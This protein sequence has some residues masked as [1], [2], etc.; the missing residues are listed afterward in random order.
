M[1]SWTTAQ[2][3]LGLWVDTE[4]MTVGLPQRTPEDLQ[5]RL[6]SWPSR[7]RDVLLREV[8]S[9]SRKLHPAACFV[10]P[11]LY[12]VHRLLRL[13]SLYLTVEGAWSRVRKSGGEEETRTDYCRVGCWKW[14]VN[15]DR[16]KTMVRLAIPFFRLVKQEPSRRWYPDVSY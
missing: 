11:R 1:T 8:L 10:R 6:E 13:S 5:Q 9:L 12:F 15:Q 7:R 14:L 3:L 16:W 4:D 2:E